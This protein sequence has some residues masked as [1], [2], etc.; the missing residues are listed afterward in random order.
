MAFMNQRG[1]IFMAFVLLLSQGFLLQ[2]QEIP[3]LEI[4]DPLQEFAQVLQ[5]NS[6]TRIEGR[7]LT[8]DTYDD[9][10][11][12]Q[13]THWFKEDRWV[14]VK[15]DAQLLVY[16]RNAGMMQMFRAMKRGAS[17]RMTIQKDRDGKRR[18]LELDGT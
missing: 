16:P 15:S 1:M 5:F 4:P 12:I 7:L 6:P 8:F 18:V 17:I 10:I 2:A 9:A 13:W 11:W 14:P 3:P